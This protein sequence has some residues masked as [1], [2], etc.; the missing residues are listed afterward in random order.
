MTTELKNKER[1][2]GRQQRR[3]NKT[4]QKLMQAAREIFAEKGLATTRIDEI[5][6]RADVGKGTFYYH[7][8]TKEVLIRELMQS[9]LGELETGIEKRC[10]GIY[11]L[12]KLLDTIIQCHLEFFGNRWEDFV[13]FFQGRADLTLE[14]SYE[15]IE[16]PFLRYLETIENL[17]DS[18]IKY[19][20]SKNRLQRIACAVAGFVSG[21]YSFAFVADPDQDIEKTF[22][23]MRQAL[24]AGLARFVR[25]SIPD[26]A[27][28][29][30]STIKDE[31]VS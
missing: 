25:E 4:R 3:T 20:L 26:D 15:G 13:L 14:E 5:T 29:K 24:V 22:G 9:V 18:V 27:P 17:L 8:P 10:K 7:F 30:I 21:Y 11:K 12:D 16:T 28:G 6:E 23:L 2:R 1:K 31:G 19:H